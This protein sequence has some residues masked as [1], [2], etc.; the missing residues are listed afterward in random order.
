MCSASIVTQFFFNWSLA[1][2][3][4]FM[5]VLGLSTLPL[6]VV[7]GVLSTIMRVG[8]ATLNKC[9]FLHDLFFFSYF[10]HTSYV[11]H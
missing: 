6:I 1:N 10:L 7:I 4:S 5:A 8:L 11:V 9:P 3:G 2:V